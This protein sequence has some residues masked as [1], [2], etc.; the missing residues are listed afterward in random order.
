MSQ[1][2]PSPLENDAMPIYDSKYGLQTAEMLQDVSRA[3]FR[4]SLLADTS[5]GAIFKS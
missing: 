4:F 5:Y 2:L 1:M 3:Y